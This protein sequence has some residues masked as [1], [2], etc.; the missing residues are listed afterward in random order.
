MKNILLIILLCTTIPGISQSNGPGKIDW[1]TWENVLTKTQ[2]APRKIM[3]F[4][5]TDWVGWGKRMESEINKTQ[6]I[7]KL[8]NNNY[9]V[10][11]MDAEQK[12]DINISGRI[13]KY[14]PKGRRGYH[15]LAAELLEGRLSYPAIVF[16]DEKL[17][18]ITYINGYQ[19]PIK[20]DA[21]LNYFAK[22]IYKEISFEQ[23][24]RN[25][26]IEKG[27]ID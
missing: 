25:Y 23:Y 7:I 2:S 16:I 12:E 1:T 27:I 9:Y 11:K 10:I 6:E 17:S 20:M 22:D 13:Y 18:K 19:T 14:I 21:I 24:W 5:T 15:E 4:V 3:V 26:K 8:L